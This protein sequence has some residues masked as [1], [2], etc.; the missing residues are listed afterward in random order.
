MVPADDG[1]AIDAGRRR[2]GMPSGSEG[3]RN[4]ELGV[5]L[6]VNFYADLFNRDNRSFQQDLF[7][8]DLRGNDLNG[9]GC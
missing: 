3:F 9:N 2:A 6:L 8:N 7:D 5:I 4:K 1:V